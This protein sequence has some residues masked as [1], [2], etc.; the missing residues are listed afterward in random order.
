MTPKIYEA[1]AK[2]LVE[3]WGDY[4]GWA[5]SVLFTADLRAFADYGL[6][7][8]NGS[9]T[10]SSLPATP[11]S[12]PPTPSESGSD[13]FGTPILD[14]PRKRKARQSATPSKLK[15]VRTE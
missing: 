6:A 11:A 5:H 14:T 7:T 15:R 3:T 10:K 2:K 13:Y 4:A 8:P 12:V 1:V 9:P